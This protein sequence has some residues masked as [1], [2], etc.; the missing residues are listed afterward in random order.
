MIQRWEMPG[1]MLPSD[2]E[3]CDH[4]Q[5]V[6]YNAHVKI[7][8]QMQTWIDAKHDEVVALTDELTRAKVTLRRRRLK[9]QQER[10]H[11]S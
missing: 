9:K 1:M 4:G 3:A 8:K 11:G 2:L 10:S 5:L 7:T 6:M